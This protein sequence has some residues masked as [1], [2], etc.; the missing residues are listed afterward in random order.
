LS[1]GHYKPLYDDCAACNNAGYCDANHY[2][3]HLFEKH[4]FESLAQKAFDRGI[5]IDPFYFHS[6]VFIVNQLV[7]SCRIKRD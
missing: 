4:N 2:K 5:I 3:R 1:S 7:E 6:K